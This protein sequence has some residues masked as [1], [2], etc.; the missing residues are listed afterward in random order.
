MIR[1]LV[2]C[3][4][5]GLGSGLRY[6]IALWAGERLGT[7]FPYGTLIVNVI[8]SFAMALAMEVSLRVVDF[9]PNLR[10]AITTGLLGGFT[11]YSSFNFE[12]TTLALDGQFARG[13]ANVAI[14]L[15]ACAA[16]GLLGFALARKLTG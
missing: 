15:V 12:S 13:F 4:A 3:G 1:F 14:T 11:T 5:G 6:L 16:A 7:A 2:V 10:L 8:G 9:P